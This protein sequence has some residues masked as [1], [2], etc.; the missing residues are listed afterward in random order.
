[1]P[2][3]R[4]IWR[5][6]R[7][8]NMMLGVLSVAIT[9]WLLRAVDLSG[10]L[11]A[12]AVVALFTGGANVTNDVFDFEIDKINRPDRPLPAGEISRSAAIFLAV[13]LY[14]GGMIAAFFLSRPA[15]IIAFVL[16]LPLLIFY[17]PLLKKIPLLGNIT[18]A[19]LLGTVFL[20][21]EAALSSTV[22]KMWIPAALAFGLSL[23]RELVKDQQDIP[24]DREQGI[25][26]FP[27]RFG[28][29]ASLV[30]VTILVALLCLLA[31]LPYVRDLYGKWYLISLIFGV[32]VPLI[33]SIFYLWKNPT[34][35]ASG[36]ISGVL[37]LTTIA[38]MLVIFL[39]RSS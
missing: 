29:R 22:E 33:L 18:I 30:L 31:P 32:E 39:S 12:G 37:K 34:S 38:G 5:M 9:A 3:W 24:G 1:M 7:P 35:A 14:A 25:S 19:A 13:C 27:A 17:T 11:L 4:V 16:V 26:T 15:Q 8:L 2:E 28:L 23:I 21:G 10:L 20:F 36:K 6:V